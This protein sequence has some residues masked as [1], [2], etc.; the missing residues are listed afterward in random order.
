MWSDHFIWGSGNDVRLIFRLSRLVTVVMGML[1]GCLIARWARELFGPLGGAMALA[2]YVFAPNVLAHS[3]LVTDDMAVAGFTLV[4]IY[5]LWRFY[6]TWRWPSLILSGVML[7]C[8]QAVKF[9]AAVLLPLFG[10]LS[11]VWAIQHRRQF[12]RM[13]TALAAV[14]I[15]AGLT[16]WGVYGFQVGSLNEANVAFP[17]PA[18]DYLDDLIWQTR[19]MGRG[20]G[21]YLMGEIST[22]GWWYYDLIA[23]AIKTPLPL[24]ILVLVASARSLGRREWCLELLLP[25]AVF[26]AAACYSRLDIGLRYLLPVYPFLHIYAARVAVLPRKQSVQRPWVLGVSLVIAWLVVGTV[27]IAPHYLAYFNE[28]IGGPDNGPQYLVDSNLDW[29]QAL[30]SL[31]QWMREHNVDSVYLS[32]F[33]TAHPSAY[34]IAFTAIPTWEAAPE[35][36]NPF[37]HV[38]VPSDPVPGIYAISATN[39]FGPTVPDP[40][41]F[42]WFRNR[43]PVARIGYAIYI[44]QVEPTGPPL[45]VALSGLQVDEL[46]PEAIA[47]FDTNDLRLRWFDARHSLVFSRQTTTWMLIAEDTP[48]APILDEQFATRLSIPEQH[49]TH[50]DSRVYTAYRLP[51][52]AAS[53]PKDATPSPVWWSPATAFPPEGF[54][55]H[56]LTLPVTVGP[57]SLTGYILDQSEIASGG[58]L[59]LLTCWRVTAPDHRDLKIFAHLLDTSGQLAAGQDRLDVPTPGW[60]DED[61]IVQVHRLTLKPDAAL[62]LYQL[63][64]CPT[65]VRRTVSSA[66]PV[67]QAK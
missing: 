62:G 27:S 41:I 10:L 9:T 46:S 35:K 23:L 5:G 63:A 39:L 25:V 12:W 51:S 21:A 64:L 18:P 22:A 29:G 50:K 20:H 57:V 59:T 53:C 60:R 31:R 33:G 47:Q 61:L 65:L 3:H 15:V 19:Y 13:A 49:T 34:D 4:A 24:L 38:F 26:V 32:Y 58:E 67:K 66:F 6:R 2:L 28:L 30:P 14:L 11:I 16:I 42:A 45:N 7:G 8:A 17:V 37:Q 52:D 55:R 40:E 56:S 48:L 36:G 54:E 43:D 44:Y 1:T